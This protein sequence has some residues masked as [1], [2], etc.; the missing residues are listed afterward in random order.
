MFCIQCGNRLP[1]D[2]VFC[3]ACGNSTKPLNPSAQPMTGLTQSSRITTQFN[4]S[5]QVIPPQINGGPQAPVA[6]FESAQFGSNPNNPQLPPT[7]L[8]PE[9][10][11]SNTN[12][13]LYPPIQTGPHPYGSN[14]AGQP[15]QSNSLGMSSP[16]QSTQYSSNPL[17]Q[18]WQVPSVP[19]VPAAPPPPPAGLQ[20]WLIRTVGPNLASNALFGVSLGGA[21]AAIIGALAAII[22][23]SIAHAIAPH[24]NLY[25]SGMTGEDVIDYALGINPLHS[26]FRDGL[27]LLLIMNGVG[28]HIQ[29]NTDVYSYTSPLDGMLIIPA[30]ALTFGGYLA[31]GTDV[32]N[33]VQSSL[34]RGV[35]IAIPYTILLF[36]M[37]T[38]V[39]GCIPNSPAYICSTSSSANNQLTMDTTTLLLFGVLWGALFGLLG[40]S[41]KLA[42]GEWRHRFYLYL[43]SNQRPQVV[44]A[45]VG[46]FIAVGIGAA[47]SFLVVAC[48]VAYTS[49]SSLLLAR[50]PTFITGIVNGD[51]ASLTL[52]T[53]AWGPLYGMNVFFFSMNAPVSLN[54][55]NNS[56]THVAISLFGSTPQ[57][58]PWF[59]LL[60]AIPVI[61]LFFGGRASAALGRVQD[62][63]AGALQG[64]LIAIPFTVLVML[65]T[66]LS[67][68]TY[69]YLPGNSSSGGGFV[70]SA[71]VGA[72][73]VFLWAL[74]AGAVIGALGGMY[75]KS[76]MNVTL[77]QVF[78]P[79]AGLVTSLSK[80]GYALFARVSKQPKALQRT[81]T[82]DW[83][84]ST[85]FC[86]LLL[87]IGAGVVG[88][89]LVGLNQTL[90]LD[91]NLRMRDITSVVL[92]AVPGLLVLC[93]C[94]VALRRDPIPVTASGMPRGVPMSVSSYTGPQVP[95]YSQYP[96][97]P[98]LP[99][100][101]QPPY[102]QL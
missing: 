13:P 78:K 34:W 26:V 40:A 63:A 50:T 4:N 74:L 14:P 71:G 94:A 95:Q 1:D 20:Q 76:T 48:F 65:L 24:I 17:S 5:G 67:T 9:Q 19:A 21:L 85:A 100:Q 47:L 97:P 29:N 10:F 87:L 75:Q 80:P 43:R 37:T 18:P 39:N 86:S 22:S 23:I 30:I 51:W 92:I 7:Q 96:Q 44:G 41:I 62:V 77:S 36:L 32:Q 53:M 64:A 46:S 45:I 25:S 12:Y 55:T 101:Q 54:A 28:S 8:A 11:S 66:P 91:Q 72:F 49:Y 38:Q 60:L 81:S 89:L 99:Q 69:S 27:Q 6:R 79:L 58:S 16:Y 83:L 56:T 35:S 90:T 70:D 42:R 3:N 82:K 15:V 57:L 31:A 2:A 102:P 33:R 68:I 88:G 59:H 98:Q 84:F 61:C 73:D 52:W 93:T